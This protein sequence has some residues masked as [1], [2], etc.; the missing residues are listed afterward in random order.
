[1][2]TDSKRGSAALVALVLFAD[3]GCAQGSWSSVTGGSIPPAASPVMVFDSV[4][5]VSVLVV[6]GG[7][8]TMQVWERGSGPWVMRGTGSTNTDIRLHAAAA[9]DSARGVTV[10]YGGGNS[11]GY[12]NELAEWNGVVWRNISQS[13]PV[14]RTRHAMAYDS[15]RSVTVLFGGRG[16]QDTWTWDGS[17]WLQQ[18]PTSFPALRSGPAMAYDSR[19]QRIVLFGGTSENVNGNGFQFHYQDTWE[20]DGTT[21]NERTPNTGLSPQARHE[22]SMAFDPVT[23]F[24]YLF[25]GA[26]AYG[27]SLNDLWAWDGSRW[28]EVLAQA[29]PARRWESAMA[30]DSGRGKIVVFGGLNVLISNTVTLPAGPYFRDTHDYTPGIVG[31]FVPFGSGCAGSRG[32]PALRA[33]TGPPVAGQNFRVQVDNLPLSGPAFLFLGASNTLYG[34]L[35][36]PF[37]LGMIGMPGCDLLVSGDTLFPV[38]NILGVGLWTMDVPASLS[39]T[40]LYQQAFAVDPPANATGLTVSRGVRSRVGG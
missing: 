8:M 4:R 33:P 40:V 20:W 22:H 17:T 1:M 26:D 29:P 9:F 11:T 32:V 28:V 3:L 10:V 36:L 7:N 18:R 16:F 13:G 12:V 6:F 38:A 39:G 21:W 31:E 19:R 30:F 2:R 23:G 5:N 35:P 24:T 25:G 14:F 27:Y 15:A 34:T 37:A